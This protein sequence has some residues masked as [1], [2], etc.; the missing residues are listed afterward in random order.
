M[1]FDNQIPEWKNAGTEPSTDLKNNGF[2]AGFKP[3]AGIFNWFWS[4]VTKAI[5]E[6]QAKLSDHADNKENPHNV[7]TKQL[8]LDKVNNTADSEKSVKFARFS[9]RK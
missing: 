4:K 3:P 1:N 7:T 5:N 9:A 8:G 6:L 2:S